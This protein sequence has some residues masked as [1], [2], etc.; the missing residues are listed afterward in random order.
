MSSAR[1]RELHRLVLQALCAVPGSDLVRLAEHAEAAL[2]AAA[3]LAY[4]PAA[5][6][7]AAAVGAHREA[8]AQ[9]AR[10]VHFADVLPATERATLLEELSVECGVVGDLQAGIDA[11][12]QAIELCRQL[13][14][15]ARQALGLCRLTSLLVGVGRNDDAESASTRALALLQPRPPGREL[16]LALRTQGF[17]CMLRRDNAQ[18]IDWSKQAIALAESCADVETIASALNS[19]AR[20]RYTLTTTPTAPSSS[21]A[22][23]SL[24]TPA[25]MVMSSTRTS[26]WARHLARFIDSTKPALR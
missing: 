7:R 5:A 24:A 15:I 9:F 20:R 25:W 23:R 13:G 26:T 3:V 10:A 11:R 22:G 14:D 4:A 16:A 8:R 1:R 17:L 6:R 21:A 2:D 18:A 19:R 12:E